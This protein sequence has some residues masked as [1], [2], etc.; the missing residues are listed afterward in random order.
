[1]VPEFAI[2][3][4]QLTSWIPPAGQPRLQ[5]SFGRC[6]RLSSAQP[7]IHLPKG[8]VPR[9]RRRGFRGTR[10]GCAWSTVTPDF[11]RFHGLGTGPK[12]FEPLTYRS[13]SACRVAAGGGGAGPPPP[14]T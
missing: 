2:T 1:M 3:K 6:G 8:K 13:P 14:P 5:V 9:R 7:I 11:G 4:K 10:Q 12:G